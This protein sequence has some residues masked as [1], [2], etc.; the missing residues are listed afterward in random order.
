M[1][2]GAAQGFA[3][4]QSK[5]STGMANDLDMHIKRL[6]EVASRVEASCEAL[7]GPV[8]TPTM[9]SASPDRPI[10]NVASRVRD[11]GDIISRIENAV[12]RLQTGI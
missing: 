1:D 9:P 3:Q 11:L 5:P 2:Y 8:P 7:Y 4:I 6:F 12:T 10:S